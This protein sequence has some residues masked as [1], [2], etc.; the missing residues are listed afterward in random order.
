MLLESRN[1]G[2]V[3]TTRRG[4]IRAVDGL[5]L[6]VQPGE[7]LGICGRSG[8]GKSTLL[9]ML[10]GLCRP[11]AGTVRIDGVDLWS[12][13]PGALATF[14]AR[15]FGFLFQF[16]GLLPNLRAVDNIA[17]PALLGGVGYQQAYDRARELLGQVGL[18][19]RWDAYAGELSGGQQRRVALARALVNRP[20]LLL[21]D[22][23]TNDLDEQA[24]REVLALL[25]ELHR[26][27]HT[28]LIVVT[29]D[30]H[31]ASQADRFIY[32]QSGKLVSV[33]RPEPAALAGRQSAAAAP[34][35][36]TPADPESPQPALAPG[37]PTPLGA[38]LGRFLVGFVGWV[39]LVAA[40][41]WGGN[42]LTARFQRQAIVQKQEERKQSQELA[43]QQLRADIEDVTYRPDGGYEVSLYVNNPAA[44]KP[45]YV[46]GPSARVFVQV[47]RSWQGVPVSAAGFEERGV[48]EVTGKQV[49]R[50]AF[51]ADLPRYE[52]QIKGYLHVRV[53]NV[54]VVSDSP[55]PA[56]DLFQRTDDYYV[57]LKPQK[58]SDDEV[59]K[60]NGWKGGAL[61]P[62]WIAMPS[63]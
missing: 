26:A 52:E 54:M 62:R 37:E 36:P 56:D 53:T 10:G 15:R 43:L 46:L 51:R 3:Y 61:V 21:A 31:L 25:R 30:S 8:S 29:H 16:A 5:D 50:F 6:E 55:E 4:E 63:H 47:D 19:E 17:L 49:Y 60:R 45:F 38:G 48:H 41:L 20:L 59:R 58:V 12:L 32:L 57:Y 23:P 28:T 33:V 7:F 13:R 2:K 1:L 24:E 18:G 22:E 35:P 34:A 40:V 42:F 9:G 14:R 11:S 44:K 39:L 27:H